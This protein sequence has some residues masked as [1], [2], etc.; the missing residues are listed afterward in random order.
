MRYNE[1]GEV[2]SVNGLFTGHHLGTPLQDACP[3]KPEDNEPYAIAK[4]TIGNCKNTLCEVQPTPVGGIDVEI[5][6]NLPVPLNFSGGNQTI[7]APDGT[8]VKSAIIQKPDGLIPENIAEGVNIAG[9]IGALAAGGGAVK[10]ACG[11]CSY[12]AIE[13][14][15]TH[16]LGVIPDLIVVCGVNNISGSDAG[17][18][19]FYA[20]GI[21]SA[22]ANANGF[23]SYGGSV[24][25]AG[26]KWYANQLTVPLESATSAGGVHNVTETQ[27][28]IPAYFIDA[29]WFAFTGLT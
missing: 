11:A 1:F 17:S 19:Y 13:R 18:R 16:N 8:A 27:F 22:F 6:E 2:I 24:R 25:Y 29:F 21:N 5:L 14:T 23:T 26:G 10:M 15:I 28:K 7:T 9:I 20:F 12:F 3:E 4:Q